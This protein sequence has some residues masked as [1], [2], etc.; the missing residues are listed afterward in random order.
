MTSMASF[1]P[2]LART[3]RDP[4]IAAPASVLIAAIV[5]GAILAAG[6]GGDG[7]S[8]P[9]PVFTPTATGGAAPTAEP[10][11]TP[12]P[13][14]VIRDTA[15][16]QDLDR[17]ALALEEL[18]QDFGAYPNTGGLLQTLCAFPPNDAGC[19]LRAYID[20]VPGDL[21]RGSIGGYWY[22]SDGRYYELY[23]WMEASDAG[24]DCAA[25]DIPP[26]LKF[27]NIIY[28]KRGPEGAEP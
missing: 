1:V 27:A 24:S 13:G 18:A 8:A 5:V 12:D 19:A 15:R 16:R 28:C 11:P 25:A 22:L 7:E 4:W 26:E 23:A 2:M 3:M 21:A 20:P 6:V 10:T 9:A 14:A 17:I